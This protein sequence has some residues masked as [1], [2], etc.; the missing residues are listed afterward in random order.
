M[1]TQSPFTQR[2]ESTRRLFHRR[3]PFRS[4]VEPIDRKSAHPPDSPDKTGPGDEIET[5][6]T[7]AI[8]TRLAP[9]PARSDHPIAFEGEER[10][11]TVERLREKERPGKAIGREAIQ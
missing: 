2:A 8:V 10:S 4:T 9:A 11:A 6:S 3:C 1:T 5:A 7:S